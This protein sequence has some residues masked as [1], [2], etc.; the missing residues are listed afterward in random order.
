MLYIGN[1]FPCK[2]KN[3]YERDWINF[4][5]ENFILDNFEEDLNS[6]IKKEQGK[7]FFSNFSY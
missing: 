7:P 4:E 5:Q 6:I 1:Q 3:I 2:R